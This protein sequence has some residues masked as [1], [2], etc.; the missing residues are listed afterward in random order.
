MH[1]QPDGLGTPLPTRTTRPVTDLAAFRAA[2]ALCAI[3][4]HW[5]RRDRLWADLEGRVWDVCSGCG[6]AA[7]GFAGQVTGSGA[8]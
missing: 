3:C 6:D 2:R 4:R 8:R 1:A 5:V 7:D